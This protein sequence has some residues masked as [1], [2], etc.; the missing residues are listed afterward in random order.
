MLLNFITNHDENSWQGTEY[1]RMGNYVPGFAIITYLMPGIPLIYTGQEASLK[2]RLRFFEKDTVMWNDTTL[3]SFYRKLNDLKH[4]NPALRA[5]S[6]AGD[7]QFYADTIANWAVIMRTSGENKV[8][9]ILN[10]SNNSASVK[11]PFVEAQGKYIGIFNNKEIKIGNKTE[12]ILGPWEFIV[13][14]TR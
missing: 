6:N 13:L 3:F 5:G 9:G 1:E 14:E 8:I 11:I 10:F 4:K 2:K 7:L 12:I